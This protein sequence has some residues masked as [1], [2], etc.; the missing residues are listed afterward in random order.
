M[1]GTLCGGLDL[2]GMQCS[3][4]WHLDCPQWPEGASVVR[5]TTL[6]ALYRIQFRIRFLR[7]QNPDENYFKP[8]AFLSCRQQDILA[9]L[10]NL[11]HRVSE[12]LQGR[13]AGHRLPF[14]SVNVH[15]VSQTERPE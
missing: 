11:I 7:F 12:R 5:L 3:E 2:N 14:F 8:T 6:Q 9:G 13:A 1:I 15:W 4:R 10:D